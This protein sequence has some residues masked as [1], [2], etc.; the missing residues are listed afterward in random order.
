MAKEILSF[1]A[2]GTKQLVFG[3]N[4]QQTNGKGEF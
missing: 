3:F 1:S 2:N 4:L